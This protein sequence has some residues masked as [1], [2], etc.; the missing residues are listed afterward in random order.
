MQKAIAGENLDGWLFFNFRH[1]DPVADRILGINPETM[2]TRA[3]YY[4]VPAVGVPVKILH[5]VEPD[6]LKK[7]PGETV[8]YMNRQKL[9]SSLG[10]FSGQWGAQYSEELSA[11]SCLDYGT[12]LTIQ[13]AGIKLAS[14]A[15]LIQRFCGLIDKD[16]IQMHEEAADHLYDIVEQ[17]WAR[18]SKA[19]TAPG[20]KLYERDVQQWIL[21][22][23]NLRNL[24]TEHLPV[25]ACGKAS[26]NPHYAAEDNEGLILKDSV[27]Q[28]D[29]WAKLRKPDSVFADISWVGFTGKNIPGDA[30]KLFSTVTEARDRCAEIIS[31]GLAGGK[32]ITGAEADEAARRVLIEHGYEKYIKHRTGHGIDTELH[33]NG[34]GL[35]S[36]EFPDKRFLLEGSCF[37]IEPGLYLPEFGMRTEIDAYINGG[38]LIISGRTPQKSLLT[39]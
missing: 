3:W 31:A 2:N 38:M 13:S 22:E 7:L 14:S 20:K 15:A 27:L 23:F 17:V 30:D 8:M 10:R 35:D 32:P 11:L 1:R 37:S 12:A 6:Q 29:L 5:E 28:L 25:V 26:G 36:V 33:G 16:Q 9:I 18:L 19:L 34:T 21:D 4:L 24:E 39:I